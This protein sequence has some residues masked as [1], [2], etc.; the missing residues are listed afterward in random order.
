MILEQLIEIW[1]PPTQL[2]GEIL[3][4]I[5]LGVLRKRLRSSE[6]ITSRT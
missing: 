3:D 2:E 6:S 5:V 4:P 1:N